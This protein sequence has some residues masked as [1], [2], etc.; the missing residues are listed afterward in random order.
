MPVLDRTLD[1]ALGLARAVLVLLLF[2]LFIGS[3]FLLM[4]EPANA[5]TGPA[6]DVFAAA[7]NNFIGPIVDWDLMIG[8][9]AYFAL[10]FV[11]FGL[12]MSLLSSSGPVLKRMAASSAEAMAR[13]SDH[14]RAGE[15]FMG[16]GNYAAA[17]KE[18]NAALKKQPGYPVARFN[19]GRCY[20]A[21]GDYATAVQI[22]R[23][24][25][26]AGP[27]H[28]EAS[29][30]AGI[31]NL[32]SGKPGEAEKDLREAIRLQ[33]GSAAA[34]FYLGRAD[35]VAGKLAEAGGEYRRAK[36]IDPDLEDLD[37][38]MGENYLD[39]GS[40]DEALAALKGAVMKKPGSDRAH[41]K[42]GVALSKKGRYE[43]AVEQYNAAIGINP[44]EKVYADMLELAKSAIK[45]AASATVQKEIVRE[46]VKVPCKYCGS[47]VENTRDRCP[48][49]GAPL[50]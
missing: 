41:Y 26:K 4:E 7:Y 50:K 40:I 25:A 17:I 42:L 34:H 8:F 44:G 21:I 20:M 48:A 36:E 28:F 16:S 47:L 14:F 38:F 13:A 23:E 29:L 1:K 2:Y 33:P 10:L 18:F 12:V 11:A 27:Y 30:N 43:E 35:H 31:S 15:A 9:F 45:G 5:L 49:C 46:I 24:E 3:M 37:L 39:A 22:F 19:L 32:R 6:Y